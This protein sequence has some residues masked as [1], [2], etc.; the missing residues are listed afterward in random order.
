MKQIIV[1]LLIL[2]ILLPGCL[3]QQE[4]TTNDQQ[5]T[6]KDEQPNTYTLDLV[7]M[8]NTQQDCWIVIDSKVYDVTDYVNSHPGGKTIVQ[9]CGQDATELFKT[10]PMGSGTEHS[11][12]AYNILNNYYLGELK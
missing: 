6:T 11:E 3:P 12:K 1:F 8:H 2:I 9:G 10:R 4:P 5:P 7:A